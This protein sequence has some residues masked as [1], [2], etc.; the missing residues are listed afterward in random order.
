MSLHAPASTDP[1]DPRDPRQPPN[2]AEFLARLEPP[3]ASEFT[4][5]KVIDLTANELFG[6]DDC[7][8]LCKSVQRVYSRPNYRST[9]S[10]TRQGV[11]THR[12]EPGH[13][14]ALFYVGLSSTPFTFQFKDMEGDIDLIANKGIGHAVQ[15]RAG[16]HE[17]LIFFSK[18]G[19]VRW[20]HYTWDKES[21]Q[22]VK[23]PGY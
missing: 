9:N 8:E 13:E 19:N 15:L 5:V 12:D 22:L 3:D 1:Q 20:P 21:E 7:K 2:E 4:Q 16:P 14:V 6:Q 11:I 17:L 23:K 10:E 18:V